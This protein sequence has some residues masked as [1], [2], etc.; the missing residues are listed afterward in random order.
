MRDGTSLRLAPRDG[1]EAGLA[2]DP[3]A[4]AA[5]LIWELGDYGPTSRALEPA[6]VV[7]VET[8][9]VTSG[10]TV[11]DV[12]AGHGN[13]A[14]AAARRGATV[15]ATDRSRAMIAAGRSRTQAVGLDVTWREADAQALPFDDA[16]FDRVTSVFGA[17][18]APQPRQVARELVRVLRPGGVAGL[19]AWTRDGLAADLEALG[20]HDAVD[21]SDAADTDD[22][23]DTDT[24]PARHRWGEAADVRALFASLPCRVETRQRTLTVEFGSWREWRR[25][26]D[27]HGMTVVARRDMTPDAYHALQDGIQA[28]MVRHNHGEDG[29]VAYDH[30]YLEIIVTRTP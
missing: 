21:T 3:R 24:G 1:Q 5:R 28:V 14:V 10:H 15:T 13:G 26:H 9:G 22:A 18:F 20:A 11:L 16:S 25:A 19:T 12:A 4:D 30:G 27:A 8:I 6:S 23:V 2:H 7:L 17:I 29:R